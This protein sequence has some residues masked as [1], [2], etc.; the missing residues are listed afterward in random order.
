MPL[1]VISIAQ[2]REWEK[3]TWSAGQTELNVIRRVGNAVARLA[4]QMTQPGESILI[5]AGKGNN[6]QDALAAREA[7]ADRHAE[8]VE[9]KEPAAD[10]RAMRAAVAQKPRLIIDGLFGIGLS[11]PLDSAWTAIIEL[12]NQAKATVLAIDLPSGLNADT[13]ESYGA[14]VR[15]D[16]TLTVGAPKAGL[17]TTAGAE[18]VGRLEIT[19][20]VGF[21]ACPCA[22]QVQWTLEQDFFGFPPA[23]RAATHK[24]TYGHLAILAGSLGFHGAAVLATRG[25]QRAQP[26]LITVLTPEEVYNPV[27]S[28]LQAAMVS[29]WRGAAMVEGPWTACLAGPGLAAP[30]CRE[31]LQPAVEDL[32]KTASF[33][34]VVDASALDWLPAGK[35]PK[36]ACRV[37][38]PHPGE[39]ARLLDCP[40]SDIQKDRPESV[41]KLSEKFGG[42]WA[43]LKGHQTVIGKNTGEI[44]VNSSGNPWLAQGGSGDVLAG[45]L[46]GWLAQPGLGD[47]MTALRYGVWQH[48]AAADD[49][50]GN[51]PGWTIEELAERLGTLAPGKPISAK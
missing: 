22:S 24:G 13:G 1:P 42:A 11:R 50:Q 3:A 38:T 33:P 9:V 28:Q 6:G 20:D 51:R 48:G 7:L 34:V 41:R 46:A 31:L 29:P 26:G 19:P 8:V 39:A 36:G 18:F 30:G 10:I 12:V 37:L 4:L 5:I 17:L 23:R 25:A 14:V 40:V 43:V 35:T 21:V 15:A 32:W 47:S 45:Y 27:A 16:V 44:Y 49:L 2:M